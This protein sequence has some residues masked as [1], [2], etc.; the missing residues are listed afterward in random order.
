[1]GPKD[2]VFTGAMD[3]WANV[4]AVSWCAREVLPLVRARRA[5]AKF[6]IVGTNPTAEVRALASLPGVRVTGRVPDVRP[7]LHHAACVVAPLRLARGVQNKV[8]E[9]MSMAKVVVAS[10]EAAE[11]IDATPG[12][13]LLVGDGARE[14][15][16]LIEQAIDGKYPD[17]GQRA[18][19]LVTARYGWDSALAQLP[20]MLEQN[21]A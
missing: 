10:K 21:L 12:R 19:T 18:R 16:A 15:A 14:L 3:Y 11:G 8:L 5:D 9:A 6:W 7:Y 13:D 17:M 2:L 4:D 20:N 1:M